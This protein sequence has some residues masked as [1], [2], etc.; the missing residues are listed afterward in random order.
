VFLPWTLRESRLQPRRREVEEGAHG[1]SVARAE[2]LR[3]AGIRLFVFQQGTS[4]NHV[5]KALAEQTGGAYFQ[6]NPAVERV[7]KQ[8][9]SRCEAVAHFA[10]GGTQ[11]LEALGN[12]SA[13][14]LLEQMEHYR[15]RRAGGVAGRGD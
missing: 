1:V 3:A 14:L 7:A 6:F 8:L 4:S 13:A 2:E 10:L 15:W 9:P 5:F 11:A 12:E